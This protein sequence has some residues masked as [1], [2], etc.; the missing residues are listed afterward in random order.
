MSVT[1]VL[2]P[3]T[4]TLGVNALMGL[5]SVVGA[6]VAI[7]SYKN[8]KNKDQTNTNIVNSEHLAIDAMNKNYS[9][10]NQNYTMICSQYKTIF[11]DE[12]LL[13]KTISEHGVKN[14]TSENGKIYGELEGL[15]FEFLKDNEGIY[16]MHITHRENEDLNVVEDLK[17]EYQLNV[18]EQSY[19]NI[20]KNLEK[21]NMQIDSE[22]VLEDNSIMIT[23]NL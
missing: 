15:K 1:V 21:H 3:T 10:Q 8:N 12:Q 18:Q 19:M 14:I 6:A 2:I 22:E 7:D 11:K 5:F 20:K 17:D 16:E 9:N 4:L 23:V 13:I